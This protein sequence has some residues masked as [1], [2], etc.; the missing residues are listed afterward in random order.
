M[1]PT[2]LPLA[3]YTALIRCVPALSELVLNVALPPAF[4]ELAPSVVAP[5][6]NCTSPLGIAP[7]AEVTVSP[8]VTVRP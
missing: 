7:V 6:R 8:K 4:S 3:L 2:K 1:S 5:S